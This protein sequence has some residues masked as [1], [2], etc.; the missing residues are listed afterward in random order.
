LGSNENIL[1]RKISQSKVYV[2]CVYRYECVH[3]AQ[4]VC[5]YVLLLLYG[6]MCV[7]VVLAHQRVYSDTHAFRTSDLS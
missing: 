1:M 7:I 2:H 3:C 4:S 6:S 5:V